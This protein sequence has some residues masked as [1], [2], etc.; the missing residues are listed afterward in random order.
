MPARG[1]SW[2]R[3]VQL[4]V[5]RPRAGDDRPARRLL[6]R[7]DRTARAT[8]PRTA[9]AQGAARAGLTGPVFRQ[10]R[11]QL[12]VLR[13]L[14]VF[15]LEGL[16]LLDQVVLVHLEHVGD[17][18]RG[19]FEALASV[20]ASALHPLHDVAVVLFHDESLVPRDGSDAVGRDRYGVAGDRLAARACGHA[21]AC[22]DTPH[23]IAVRD[24]ED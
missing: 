12:L 9:V 15:L 11:A 17:H 19:L 20:A 2:R 18:T 13:I 14:G 6:E 5:G 21:H 4:R 8:A 16:E 3:G 22:E 10:G 23:L 1:A 24:A 7:E